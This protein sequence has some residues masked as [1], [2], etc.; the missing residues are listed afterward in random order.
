MI[1]FDNGERLG[2]R[3]EGVDAAADTRGAVGLVLG[4]QAGQ[5]QG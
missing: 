3:P 5:R 4:H 2:E 1:P